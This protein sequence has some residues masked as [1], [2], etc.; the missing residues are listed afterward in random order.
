[1]PAHLQNQAFDMVYAKFN[2]DRTEVLRRSGLLT[3]ESSPSKNRSDG[4]KK[5]SKRYL[6]PKPTGQP[7]KMAKIV[8]LEDDD[9]TFKYDHIQDPQEIMQH[10][11]TVR[12]QVASTKREFS[13]LHHVYAKLTGLLR[14]IARQKSEEGKRKLLE[15]MDRLT[16]ESR[17][18]RELLA[19]H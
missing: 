13:R 11:T 18:L 16:E 12:D 14:R 3:A 9:Y 7:R 1:M 5:A 4:R 8:R 2:L 19:V 6:L 10:L 17:Q 15:E